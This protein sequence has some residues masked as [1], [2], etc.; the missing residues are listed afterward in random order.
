MEKISK[1]IIY[2]FSGTGNTGNVAHWIESIAYNY[3]I[4]I[5]IIDISKIKSRKEIEIHKNA[6]IGFCS[7]T[8][9]FNSPPYYVSFPS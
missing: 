7:P 6:L 3:K 8:Y 9:G 2:Y 5:Q 4:E 1:L